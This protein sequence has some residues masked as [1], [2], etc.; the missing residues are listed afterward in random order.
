MRIAGVDVGNDTTEVAVA[1]LKPGSAPRFLASSLVT[2]VGIKG[3]VQNVVGIIEALD[4]AVDGLGWHR[5]DL[6]L[7]LLNEAT[8]VIAD[9]AMETITETVITESAM[10][11]H[12]PLTP[13][14]C[15]LGFGITVEL[16][17]LSSQPPEKPYIVIV[18]GHV[19]FRSAAAQ[20]NEAWSAGRQVVA[21]VVQN[22]D[23][24]LICNRLHR[25][26]PIVDE[27]EHVDRIP[28][29]MP[30]A[31]EVAPQGRA[32][33]KLSNPYDIATIF[34]LT[35]DET[36]HVVPVARALMGTRS[37]VVIKTPRGEIQERRIPAGKL[38]FIGD[39]L[40][41]EVNVDEGADAIMAKVAEVGPL[42]EIQAEHG[43]HVGGMFERVRRVMAELT[44]QPVSAIRVQDIM[45]VDTM[46]PQKV[47]GGLAGEYALGNA[48]ALAA[49]VETR[50]LPMQRVA[51]KLEAEIHVAV[52]VGGVEAEAA[53]L[54]ALTTPGTQSP[55]AVIDLGG[56]ST[57]ASFINERE[58]MR[59]V[60]LAG[61]G[62][63]VTRLIESELG[64]EDI[65]LAEKI[66]RYPLAKTESLFHLRHEDGS[67]QF[68]QKPLEPKIF[69][70]VV[71]LTP[72]GPVPIITRE[73]L[74]RIVHV[75]KEAKR[76][77]FLTNA[78]R[79]LKRIAPAGNM[80]LIDF[81]V[82]VGG[83]AEDFEIPQMISDTLAEYGVVTG[84]ANVRGRE[85]PRNAVAT[86]LVLGYAAKEFGVRTPWKIAH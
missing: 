9:I 44:D 86:G 41:A 38:I 17:Q 15:G 7:V 54:G 46:R 29:G 28:L 66:K 67:V 27:V 74:P 22:D 83:S 58:E 18:P 71:V 80:R 49:M 84:R 60:H 82:L 61:A 59:S 5:S 39:R 10:I 8:P 1:E 43:T 31:V 32:I 81:V 56:G 30:A 76:K 65:D 20:I 48:V 35:P 14:G 19:D 2:T 37:A 6:D 77:V 13:G 36:R 53:I 3:T 52:Q 72:E 40:K 34:H 79:A 62:D 11:G 12:N 50:K 85:G 33:E 51:T 78:M 25:P 45:A 68:F 69:G 55:M 63:M 75:R 73:T 24:V 42:V 57:D 64:L 21:A 23:G 47:V 4:R 26:I 16:G 70:R